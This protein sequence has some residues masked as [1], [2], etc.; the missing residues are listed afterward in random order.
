VDDIVRPV[1]KL[2]ATIPPQLRQQDVHRPRGSRVSFGSSFDNQDYPSN[3]S[4]DASSSYQ[5]PRA[6]QRTGT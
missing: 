5:R 2:P 6:M 4:F 1:T 3:H